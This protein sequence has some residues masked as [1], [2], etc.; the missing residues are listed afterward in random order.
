MARKSKYE[1]L[2]IY[3]LSDDEIRAFVV[4]DLLR[5]FKDAKL[6]ANSS[7]AISQV[8]INEEAVFFHVGPI[9]RKKETATV[10][11]QFMMHKKDSDWSGNPIVKSSLVNITYTM[12]DYDCQNSNEPKRKTVNEEWVKMIYQKNNDKQ[13]LKDAIRYE[14]EVLNKPETVRFGPSTV[15]N[16]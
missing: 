6:V 2:N 13:Y 5:Q 9:E 1:K 3:Q 10:T 8:G 4:K 7:E 15:E 12:N 11:A 14:K 16:N